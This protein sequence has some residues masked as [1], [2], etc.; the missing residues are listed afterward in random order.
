MAL[1]YEQHASE[2]ANKILID[3]KSDWTGKRAVTEEQ[4]RKLADELCIKF[5]AR[6]S[7]R[8]SS[9][10]QGQYIPRFVPRLL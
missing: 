1:E 10:W 5:M 8:H 9:H 2:D 6:V 7:R 3:N 4:G